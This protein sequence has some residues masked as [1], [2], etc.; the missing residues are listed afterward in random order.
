MKI[1]AFYLPQFHN[2]PENDEWWGDGFT[3]WT[4]VKSGYPIYPD[5]QQPKIPLNEN[6]Y[7]LLDDEVK[8]WQSKLAKQYGIYGFCYYHYWF[9]GKMLLEKP[10]EQMLKNPKITTPFCICWANEAWTKAWVAEDRKV[11]IPQRYGEKKE[12]KEHFDYLLPFFKDNRYICKDGKPIIVI[13]RPKVISC[14]AEMINY[15]KALAVE[16]GL[17]GLAVMCAT[18]NIDIEESCF[19]YFDNLIEWQPHTAKWI[20][21][22][23]NERSGIIS[24]LK[25]LRRYMWGK[26]EHITGLDPYKY[27]P[28]ALKRQEEKRSMDYDDIWRKVIEMNPLKTNSLPGAFV[29]WDNTARYKEKATIIKG[30]TPLKFKKYLKMQIEHAKNEYKSEMIFMYAWNEWAEGGYLEP[31]EENGYAYL[32][33]IRDALLETNEFPTQE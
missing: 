29:R 16:G 33:A 27:D 2:I 17:K 4:N 28:I 3:E 24:G 6:Y 13:Y 5:H 9:N 15:W 14:I 1:I 31:D 8:I 19:D 23:S 25:K 11:L 18:N 10:M 21:S 20:D 26:I 12:W 30:E 22:S 32:E 7:N